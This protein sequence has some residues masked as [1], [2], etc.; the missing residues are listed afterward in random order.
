[1]EPQ[2]NPQMT[3][4]TQMNPQMNPQMTQM[5]QMKPQMKPPINADERRCARL[6]AFSGARVEE[7][8]SRAGDGADLKFKV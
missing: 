6:V 7:G 4:M 1:M 8:G 3:Q 5:T 2:M